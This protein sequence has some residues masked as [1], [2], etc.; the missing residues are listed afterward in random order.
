MG[1]CGDLDLS[2]HAV[3][4]HAARRID[5]VAP[6]VVGELFLA[7]HT[8]TTGPELIPIRRAAIARWLK[9]QADDGAW[10]GQPAPTPRCRRRWPPSPES[11]ERH[12]SAAQMDRRE[13]DAMAAE[14]LREIQQAGI[15]GDP[16]GL[17][18]DLEPETA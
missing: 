5:G 14:R 15:H 16:T 12:F 11:F 18:F 3:R 10:G 4:L 17:V 13:I 8:R 2:C 9:H 1:P 7:D 6:Q